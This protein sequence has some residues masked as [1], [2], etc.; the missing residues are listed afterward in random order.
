MTRALL[1]SGYH[2]TSHARWARGLRDALPEVD[3][4]TLTLPPRHFRW[5]VRGNAWW[6]ALEEPAVRDDYDVVVAT[7][8]VDL[9][10]LIGLVPSLGAAHKIVYF[11]ENQF[12]YPTRD[13]EVD[14]ALAV[15]DVYTALAADTVL[16]N[17]NFNRQ[18]LLN[19]VSWLCAK[20]P[21]FTPKSTADVIAARSAVVPVGLDDVW[22]TPRDA[23]PDGPLQIVWNHRWEYDKAPERLFAALRTLDVDFEVHVIGQQFRNVP[24][25]FALGRAALGERVATWGFVDDV[26]D[27]RRLLRRCDVVV[28][29]AL[30]EFQ[31]LAVLEAVASGCVAAVPDRLAY[32]E[33]LPQHCLYES[34]LDDA[35]REARK[36]ARHLTELAGRL[37]ELRHAPPIDLD[38][39]NWDAL[40]PQWRRVVGST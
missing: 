35:Q 40:A 16:F 8:T 27:Y 31:G 7:S 36:L 25:A 1:L 26:E 13:G 28:S 37:H 24:E 17:S 10:G 5:R 3:W 23:P 22:F 21:D 38:A 33:F 39:L 30:H 19:G 18:T 11:H 9:A 14:M 4:T 12:E 29:T 15:G 20:L 32:P 34:H 2:A 6:W